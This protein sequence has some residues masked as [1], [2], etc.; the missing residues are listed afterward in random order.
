MTKPFQTKPEAALYYA[1]LGWHVLPLHSITGGCCTC[2]KQDCSSAGKHPRVGHGLKEATTD[3]HQI[4]QWWKDWPEANIGIRSGQ[5]SGFIALDVDPRNGGA[6]SFAALI[7]EHDQLPD[8]LVADTGGGGQ[9]YLFKYP[10]GVNIKSKSSFRPGLDLKSD[11]GYIVV[12]PS[13]HISG[14]TYHFRN[15][16]KPL[17]EMPGW[18]IEIASGPRTPPPAA[19]A[20]VAFGEGSRNDSLMRTG[21]F[22]KRLGLSAE[23]LAAGLLAL[24][25]AL[26]S[27]PLDASEVMRVAESMA[28]YEN[29]ELPI[30]RFT[31]LANAELFASMFRDTVRYCIEERAWYVWD[32]LKWSRDDKG[33][34]QFKVE[35]TAALLREMLP[36]I[37]DDGLKKSLRKHLDRS[38][39]ER[40]LRA[41]VNLAAPRLAISINDFDTDPYHLCVK[42]G[43]LDLRS[44]TITEPTPASM[45]SKASSVAWDPQAACPIW[46]SFLRRILN[47]D[48]ELIA[49]V[50]RAVGYS[51]TGAVVEQ[52]LFILHGDGANGKSTFLEVIRLLTAEYGRQADFSS[53]VY[54]ENRNNVRNDIARLAGTRFVSASESD[55]QQRLDEALI[56][57]LTGGDKIAA[58]M[59]YREAFEFTPTFKIWL[60]TN[61]RPKIVGSDEGI[62]RRIHLIPFTVQIPPHEQ[63]KQLLEKLKAELPGILRWAVAGCMDWQRMG[64]RPPQVVRAETDRYRVQEDS[65][66]R[67]FEEE[68]I[69]GSSVQA[70]STV[71]QH[72]YAEWCRRNGEPQRSWREVSDRLAKQGCVPKKTSAARL[73]VGVSVRMQV[74]LNLETDLPPTS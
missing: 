5:V 2:G 35:M 31:D 37:S 32:G 67:F 52:S 71:L 21:G 39:S 36:Q 51:L 73:W 19:T 49:F 27:P 38:E 6:E 66:S 69:F 72:A 4:K 63:D 15:M 1:S 48:D 64:L 57:T 33:Q 42:N 44:G 60:A 70:T 61:H 10:E 46:I 26:C 58:R 3:A 9:H 34:I 8:T 17:A 13:D 20:A 25:Q 16:A 43:H 29:N 74:A 50:Q 22:L 7:K 18:L 65:I 28:K 23:A 54:R 68:C 53:F 30:S 47:G 59:L 11:G 12:D 14:H 41:I 40:G 45:M 24:N 56:K 55:R 62:W